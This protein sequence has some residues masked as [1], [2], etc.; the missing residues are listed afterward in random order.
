MH[1]VWGEPLGVIQ[2]IM[3]GDVHRAMQGGR[4]TVFQALQQLCTLVCSP[5][6]QPHAPARAGM[7]GGA[8]QS[9]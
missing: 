6:G 4:I 9:M 5:I 1:T 7:L 2:C 3:Y 8:P